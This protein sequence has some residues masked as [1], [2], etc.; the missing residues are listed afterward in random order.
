MKKINKRCLIILITGFT[1][2]F[3]SCK[4][5]STVKEIKGH[6]LTIEVIKLSGQPG[7]TSTIS[8]SARIIPD[9]ALIN[10]KDNK[11]KTALLF[12]MDSCFYLQAGKK[13]I[14]ASLTQPVANGVAG[15]FEYLL[16]FDVSNHKDADGSL[17]YQ[18]KYL[19]HRK[20]QI[21]PDKE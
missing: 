11:V 13:K 12:N 10:D 9:K 19:N 16:S 15:T 20:Y 17:I 14:Y 21:N 6:G 8:Y 18:D 2:L 4:S 7:D 5:K 1:A 3:T